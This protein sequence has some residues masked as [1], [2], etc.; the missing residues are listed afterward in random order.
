MVLALGLAAVGGDWSDY[1]AA[2][3]VG[4]VLVA[5]VAGLAAPLLVWGAIVLG[6]AAATNNPH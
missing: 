1:P 4:A 6:V 5:L 2:V 3:Q